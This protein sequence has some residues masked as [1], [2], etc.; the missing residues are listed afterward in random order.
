MANSVDSTKVVL[1]AGAAGQQGGAVV[2]R[3]LEKGWSLR[4]LTRRPDSPASQALAKQGIDLVK[5][6]LENPASLDAAVQGFYGVFSV[7]DGAVGAVR[8]V[9]QG[10]NM[11]DAAKKAG[12]E[13]FVYTSVGGADR[14]TGI[15]IWERK[16]EVENHIRKIGLPYTILRPTS[17]FEDYFFQ[18]FEMEILRGRLWSPVRAD[19]PYQMIATW[20][21]GG[22]VQLAFERPAE[23]IGTELE[24]AGSALTNREA[25]EVFSKVRK[26]KVTFHQ[27]PPA[28]T[29]VV[30][31]KDVNKM[32]VWL[33][34]S[35]YKADVP[36]LRRKYP[37]LQ[38]KNLE[39]WLRME[40]WHKHARPVHI[41][42]GS[43]TFTE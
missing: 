16:W 35:G 8:E 34:A 3:M 20:D 5:G 21:I 9:Q 13:H 43:W 4:A 19:Q 23:F 33:N 36:G 29:R 18:M 38:L 41:T 10:K 26:S 22:F 14:N 1:V 25:A 27:I 15:S 7:Q 6:D 28:M 31:G 37:E 32:F 39:D 11:A 17:F 40:R 2:A 42:K 12:I 24:I 30:M